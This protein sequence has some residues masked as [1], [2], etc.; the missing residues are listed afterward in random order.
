MHVSGDATSWAAS[1]MSMSVLL[2]PNRGFM[3]ALIHS[4]RNRDVLLVV[5]ED[6]DQVV[7]LPPAELINGRLPPL[8]WLDLVV[9]CVQS[10]TRAD[11]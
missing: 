6:D 11:R 7:R 1:S 2:E 3:C 10:G 4:L 9:R 8:D 5:S